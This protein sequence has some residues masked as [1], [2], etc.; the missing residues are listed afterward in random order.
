M[1]GKGAGAAG[2]TGEGIVY[3][4]KT[5]MKEM[6]ISAKQTRLDVSLPNHTL[7]ISNI[8]H[9]SRSSRLAVLSF[10]ERVSYLNIN[11]DCA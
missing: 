6:L 2:A 3:G 8:C 4:R 5:A 1:K 7:C 9:W 11:H 10:D